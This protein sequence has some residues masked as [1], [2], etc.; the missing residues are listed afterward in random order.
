MSLVERKP[1]RRDFIKIAGLTAGGAGL[2]WALVN[3]RN[4]AFKA[5]EFLLDFSSTEEILQFVNERYGIEIPDRPLSKYS[6]E[7]WVEDESGQGKSETIQNTTLS[8]EE[9]V[10]IGTTL[11][12]IPGAG[13]LAQ[14]I[15]PYRNHEK[16]AIPGGSYMGY[17]WSRR[18]ESSLQLPKDTDKAAIRLDLP[19]DIG[20]D[21]LLPEISEGD[22]LLPFMSQ[23]GLFESG[24]TVKIA[25]EVPWTTHG[26][27]LRQ[28][29]IH[30]FGHGLWDQVALANS[31]TYK[32]YY[33]TGW[34]TPYNFNTWDVNHPILVTFAEVNGWKL[35]PYPQFVEQ[36]SPEYAEELRHEQSD[37]TKAKIWDRDPNVWGPLEDRRIRLTPYA[38]YGP[39]QETFSEFFM[40]SILYPK[41][42]S[43]KE[44]RY[45][46]R[47]HDGLRRDPQMFFKSVAEK[48]EILLED[49]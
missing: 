36:Y 23:L 3:R 6:H 14:L 46:N 22:V 9:A 20:L 43:D 4:I 17:Y 40:T 47:I 48:P 41:F 44:R 49:F 45:F 33:N 21:D 42:L 31:K 12:L 7:I 13:S 24:V 26:N 18:V 19:A 28:S 5:D 39:P 25:H 8:H 15:I 35:V 10:T 34:H 2:A 16:K 30:E 37:F 32:D 11:G 1:S 29:I 38:S 27:R